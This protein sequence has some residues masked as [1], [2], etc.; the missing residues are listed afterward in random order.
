MRCGQRKPL[1]AVCWRISNAC[2]CSRIKEVLFSWR[3]VFTTWRHSLFNL[4]SLRTPRAAV[5][6]FPKRKPPPPPLHVLDR[7][8]CVK[9]I[10]HSDEGITRERMRQAADAGIVPGRKSMVAVSDPTLHTRCSSGTVNEVQPNTDVRQKKFSFRQDALTSKSLVLFIPWL[11][12]VFPSRSI[13]HP[14]SLWIWLFLQE[15]LLS[16]FVISLCFIGCTLAFM[17]LLGKVFG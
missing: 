17:L 5:T 7:L 9:V 16:N 12:L 13:N 11:Q 14:S 1:L 3:E 6:C 15:G 10:A 8:W 2:G 4:T